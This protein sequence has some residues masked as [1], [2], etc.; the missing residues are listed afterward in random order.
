MKLHVAATVSDLILELS[1]DRIEGIADDDVKIFMRTVAGWI[2]SDRDF[3]RRRREIDT[4]RIEAALVMMSMRNIDGNMTAIDAAMEP[5]EFRCA[6]ANHRLDGVG[7]G[8]A[9]E[10]DL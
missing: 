10:R 6:L 2:T 4:D 7:W 8:H 5:F 3:P 9:S 1:H